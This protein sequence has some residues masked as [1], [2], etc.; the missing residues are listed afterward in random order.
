M[1]ICTCNWSAQLELCSRHKADGLK[2]L[3][4]V[5][6][7]HEGTPQ[8]CCASETPHSYYFGETQHCL[9]PQ[10]TAL[11]YFPVT[12]CRAHTF[13]PHASVSPSLLLSPSL[14]EVIHPH[15]N[16]PQIPNL[17]QNKSQNTILL[18][19]TD[20]NPGKAPNTSQHKYVKDWAKAKQKNNEAQLKESSGCHLGDDAQWFKLLAKTAELMP[21]SC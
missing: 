1:Y 5:I 18:P 4:P 17:I 8:D 20:W 2:N 15:S 10:K 9:K 11:G 6:K 21:T 19:L 14:R 12:S 3:Q 16:K 7:T 13:I